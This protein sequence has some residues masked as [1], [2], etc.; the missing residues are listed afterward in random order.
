MTHSHPIPQSS[1]AQHAVNHHQY[2]D[3][4]TAYL[5]SSVHAEGAE[6]AKIC[7]TLQQ[8]Q[9]K[10]VLD[11]GCGGGHVSYQIA[12][13]VEQVTAYD[14][15]SD[16]VATVTAEATR[17]G[18]DNISGLVGA[19]EELPF[20]DGHFDA[21]VSRYSAHHW[22][23][24]PQAIRQIN[25]VLKPQGIAIVVDI[26]GNSNPILDNVLQTL[27]TI[28]DPSHV[29]DYAAAQWLKFAEMSGFRILSFEKQR[30]KLDFGS[31]VARMQTP[32][33]AVQTLGYVLQQ[34]S[35]DFKH[36][37][38]VQADGSFSSEVMILVLQKI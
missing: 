15:L 14:L 28:R 29:R 32:D 5:E 36:Y 18:L 33:F 11:L 17:R 25:R 21:V 24:V 3:K 12:P 38:A 13:L 10:H 31:W 27:E 34:S 4:S 6:F 9:A 2:H 37:Y 1:Y 23:S 26:L 30:L 19:A 8:Y 20:V 35:A 16:M 7:A 22:H